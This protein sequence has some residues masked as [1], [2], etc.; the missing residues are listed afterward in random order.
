MPE[1]IVQTLQEKNA[2]V[3]RQSR[4]VWVYAP[5]RSF[6]KLTECYQLNNSSCHNEDTVENLCFSKFMLCTKIWVIRPQS[7]DRKK[8]IKATKKYRGQICI[9]S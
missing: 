2:Q 9:Y 8:K 1:H 5:G 4:Q 3:P 7:E 6:F